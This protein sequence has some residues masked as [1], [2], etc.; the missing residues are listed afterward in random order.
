VVPAFV[1]G[2][3]GQVNEDLGHIDQR[4]QWFV[5]NPNLD[6][7]LVTWLVADRSAVS[8]AV[9]N[10]RGSGGADR[11][12]GFFPRSVHTLYRRVLA[13]YA[14]GDEGHDPGDFP[15]SGCR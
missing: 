1:Q 15:R 12:M 3:V 4:R 11:S 9:V 6:Y 2:P 10:G 13:R 14:D 5:M 7:V 8:Y